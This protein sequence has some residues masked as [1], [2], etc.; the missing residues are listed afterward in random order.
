MRIGTQ[1]D[2]L[3]LLRPLRRDMARL[4]RQD[5]GSTREV[6][7]HNH[8]PNGK[9]VN[10][11]YYMYIIDLVMLR[12][13]NIFLYFKTFFLINASSLKLTGKKHLIYSG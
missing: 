8:F 9:S 12:K 5:R 3:I 6:V 1:F 7:P 4:E 13:S 10:L 11:I 2:H